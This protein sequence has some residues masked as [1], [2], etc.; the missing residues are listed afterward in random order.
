VVAEQAQTEAANTLADA[1]SLV[2]KRTDELA[3]VRSELGALDALICDELRMGLAHVPGPLAIRGLDLLQEALLTLAEGRP[4]S[5]E[6]ARKAL[7]VT[8]A[9]PAEGGNA[10]LASLPAPGTPPSGA[11]MQIFV[12]LPEKVITM[13]VQASDAV[14]DIFARIQDKGGIP[15]KMHGLS[16]A[17][18]QLVLGRTFKDYNIQN[19]STLIIS[20]SP[21]NGESFVPLAGTAAV[22]LASPY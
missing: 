18:Q 3:A 10:G 2:T 17:G 6:S 19:D 13:G 1:T 22:A 11:G 7:T 15:L 21:S 4:L 20:S 9:V 16:F 14:D 12:K 5:P 8:S